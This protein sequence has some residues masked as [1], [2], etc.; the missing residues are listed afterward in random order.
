MT[1]IKLKSDIIC[2]NCVFGT[3]VDG[4]VVFCEIDGSYEYVKSFC[5][6]GKFPCELSRKLLVLSYEEAYQQ[7]T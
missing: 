3:Y 5:S 2:K 6:L 4:K 7:L 1:P